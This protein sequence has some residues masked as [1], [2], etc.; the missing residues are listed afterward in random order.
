MQ[1]KIVEDDQKHEQETAESPAI[2]LDYYMKFLTGVRTYIQA[3][4]TDM[5][6]LNVL[7]RLENDSVLKKYQACNKQA[8]ITDNFAS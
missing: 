7:Q 6:I 4:G 3:N 2:S 5:A 8:K 1:K